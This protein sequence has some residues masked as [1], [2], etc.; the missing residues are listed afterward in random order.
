VNPWTHTATDL[1]EMIKINASQ[2][3]AAGKEKKTSKHKN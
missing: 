2:V 3:G 1:D